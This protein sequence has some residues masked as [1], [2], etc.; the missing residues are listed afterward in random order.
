MA[1]NLEASTLQGRVAWKGDAFSEIIGKDKQGYIRGIGL[2]P[3]PR[4]IFKPSCSC[5]C[6][7]TV[8]EESIRQIKEHVGRLEQQV[9]NQ[10]QSTAE[11]K[12]RVQCLESLSIQVL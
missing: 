10:S 1:E 8:V 9:Q 7:G 4:E 3:S 11:L 5:S 2:G 12:C 6:E